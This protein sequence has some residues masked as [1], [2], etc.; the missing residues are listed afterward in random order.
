MKEYTDLRGYATIQHVIENSF[1]EIINKNE[2]YS[3]YGPCSTTRILFQS[4]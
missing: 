4:S 1:H 2:E 3:V